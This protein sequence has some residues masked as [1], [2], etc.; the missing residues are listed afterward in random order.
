[1]HGT[2]ITFEYNIKNYNEILGVSEPVHIYQI[3]YLWLGSAAV[4]KWLMH[5]LWIMWSFFGSISLNDHL[6][7]KYCET[8]LWRVFGLML[9]AGILCSEEKKC[10]SSM[11]G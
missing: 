10:K 3:L 7:G 11:E 5:G 9:C 6:S 2:W 8:K 4:Q 1:M